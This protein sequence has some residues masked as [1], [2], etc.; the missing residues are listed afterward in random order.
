MYSV[1][2]QRSIKE[3][4]LDLNAN[5]QAI[6]SELRAEAT[7]LMLGKT[8]ASGGLSGNI[9]LNEDGS[10]ETYEG[11]DGV[12]QVAQAIKMQN[13]FLSINT[14]LPYDEA[15]SKAFF[16]VFVAYANMTLEFK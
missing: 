2:T 8:W 1:Q 12:I 13:P 3:V 5:H 16:S 14:S 4:F 6:S 15:V 7:A 9:I 10:Y 11:M